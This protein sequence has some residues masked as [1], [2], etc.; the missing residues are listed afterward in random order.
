[1]KKYPVNTTVLA[2]ASALC[3]ATRGIQAWA[4]VPAAH[5]AAMERENMKLHYDTPANRWS[6]EALPIGNGQ[7]GAMIFGGIDLDRIQ[8]NEESL[9]IGNEIDTGAY[10]D[11]G[12]ITVRFEDGGKARNYRRELDINRAVHR[13]TYERNGVNFMREAFASFPAKVIV[14]R[15]TADKPGAI[16]GVVAM[17]DAHAKEYYKLFSYK[18]NVPILTDPADVYAEAAAN[19][20]TLL[21]S[22]RFPGYR[23]NGDRDWLPLNR[24]AQLRVLY[25]GGTVVPI[26]G[27]IQIV[28]ADSVTLLLAAGT[29]FK[30]DRTT[31][32]RG[33]LPHAMVTARL[34]IAAQ[35]TYE[36]LLEE[37]VR[38]YRHLFARVDL[39]LGGKSDTSLPTDVRLKQY[40]TQGDIGLEELVFQYGR[41]L[42]IASSRQGGLPANLQGK[43]NNSNTPP[44]ACD[45]HTDINLQMNY[46]L[47]DVTNLSECFQPYI[48]YID[49]IRA[50][51]TAAANKVFKCRGWAVQGGGGL[52][53]GGDWTWLAGCAARLLQNSFDH[54]SFT[55][56]KEYL[57]RYAYPA[58]K[59]VCEFWFD[60]LKELPDGTLVSPNGFSPEHGPP[61]GT[62]AGKY[63]VTFDQ[64]LVWDLFTNTMEAADILGC[65]KEF[66][67]L[68]AAKR[69]KLLGPKIGRWGQLQ[70]WMND[71]DDPSDMH[72]HS[73][74]LVAVYPGRQIS[75]AR[76]PALAQA[77]ARALQARC[78]DHGASFGG[79]PA[80]GKPFTVDVPK[81]ESHITWAWAFRCALWAR[82]LD[83][84]RWSASPPRWGV[85]AGP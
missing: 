50:P 18:K 22:G 75:P 37:H 19:P 70:E 53:G 54:Y 6:S 84:E 59:E 16:S 1:M 43:W 56:D 35:S 9:W 51:R 2:F 68:V 78:N 61:K 25:E 66:H 44:W 33:P 26:D 69:A 55:R 23:Y 30:Q 24:E 82:L 13:I 83:A 11:F 28:K 48:A 17:T 12:E 4:E 77:A 31:N 72:R 36:S 3:F 65:D 14:V 5:P 85:A 58:M 20:P 46:W 76:T 63:G 40:K 32:W 67:D 34:D 42:L 10:Q 80:T 47:A 7:K 60:H 21:I 27:K 73:S 41:Y 15:F 57:R 39:S 38:D 64:Q 74:H 71:V 45:Y 79:V 62:V 81:G 52:F 29:D 8:F 49:S